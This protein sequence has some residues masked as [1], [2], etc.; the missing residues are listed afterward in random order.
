MGRVHIRSTNPLDDPDFEPGYLG[1][2][3]DLAIL[4]WGYKKSREIARR[5]PSYR[6]EYDPGHPVFPT[7]SQARTKQNDHP[8]A[9][10]E[11]DFG[12]SPEDDEAIEQYLRNN[13]GTTWH[14]VSVGAK[15][16][17]RYDS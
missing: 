1:T 4:K 13:V 14:S 16:Q 6:G 3:D 5:M 2:K 17:D 12:W 7:G 10:G 15:I 9:I 8:V 11:P